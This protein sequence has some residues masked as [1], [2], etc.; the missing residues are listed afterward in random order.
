MN[1]AYS[2]GPST[3]DRPHIFVGTWTYRLPFMRNDRSVMGR[4][5]GGWEISGIY[6]Y[7]SGSP[8][9]ITGTPPTG[10]RRA[11]YIDGV[12]PYV[13][14]DQRTTLVPGSIMWL[15]PAA[16]AVAP[17]GRRGNSTRG[18]FRGPAYTLWDITFRKQIPIK[19]SVRG[20]IEATL[21]NA[22]NQL[23]YRAPATNLSGAGFGSMTSVAPPRQIQLGF[24]V[25]F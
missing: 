14:E 1:K 24:R 21:Y 20:Q 9:T 19:G 4:I 18:Q 8:L 17:A 7:Q 2:W 22:F 6:R 13:P 25:N 10:G 15:N 11:D 16:F 3:N 5:A 12:D 23:N